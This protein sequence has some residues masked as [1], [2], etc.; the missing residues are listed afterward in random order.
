MNDKRAGGHMASVLE[1]LAADIRAGGVVI[2]RFDHRPRR[3][4]SMYPFSLPGRDELHAEELHS[5]NLRW[6]KAVV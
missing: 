3:E 4:V 6:R 1:Q 2:D 5:L